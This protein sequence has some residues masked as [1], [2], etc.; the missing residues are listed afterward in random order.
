M[1]LA[2]NF[3]DRWLK[4]Y[5]P[6]L[7]KRKKWFNITDNLLVGQMVL[8]SGPDGLKKRGNYRLGRVVRVLPH[9]RKRKALVRCVIVSASIIDNRTGESQVIKMERDLAKIASLEF[10]A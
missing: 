9:I 7:Q 10:S 3:W 5:L 2:Q 1:A 6:Q 4:F 8:V